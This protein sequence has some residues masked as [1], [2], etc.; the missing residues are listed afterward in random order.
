MC[1]FVFSFVYLCICICISICVF[2]ICICKTG[3]GLQQQ[4]RGAAA[5]G[6]Q[7]SLGP[8]LLHHLA[9]LVQVPHH[10][11][12]PCTFAHLYK[13]EFARKNLLLNS[14]LSIILVLLLLLGST[15]ATDGVGT[16]SCIKL[17]SFL[18]MILTT[19]LIWHGRARL[20]P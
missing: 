4:S 8:L 7:S 2:F 3:S 6:W 5:A 19:A 11:M 13:E 17:L 14:K 12:K 20:G 10:D 1:V 18:I 9:P 16:T 15:F